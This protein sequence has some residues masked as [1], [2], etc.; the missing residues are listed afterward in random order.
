MERIRSTLVGFL[1][2][3][4]TKGKNDRCRGQR[5]SAIGI[6]DLYART[7][8]RTVLVSVG[9]G[10]RMSHTTSRRALSLLIVGTMVLAGFL[11]FVT[12]APDAAARMSHPPSAPATG[13]TKAPF[14]AKQPSTHA[15]PPVQR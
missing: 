9:R 14:V 7:N 11:V 15:A 10:T 6:N 3:K 12:A 2:R 5:N 1:V 13:V 4:R 8:P